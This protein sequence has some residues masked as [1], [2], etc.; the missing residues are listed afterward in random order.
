MTVIFFIAT[1]IFFLAADWVVQRF[2]ER[3][4]APAIAQPRAAEAAYPMR[5]PEGIFFA[6]SHTWLNLFPSGKVRL[7]IDDFVSGLV[8]DAKVA[9]VKSVGDQ[10]EKGEPIVILE[11]GDRRMAVRSPL[12]GTVVACNADFAASPQAMRKELFST[13]WIYTVQPAKPE[14]LRSLMLGTE[15]R[16]WMKEELGRLRDLFACPAG[17]LAPAT[18]QDGGA[19]APGVLKQLGAG[20]WKRFEETFLQ[21]Q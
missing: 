13:G 2:K 17:A 1:I 20:E 8:D 5:V 7:G 14:E 11:Q 6:R 19:P 15:S 16:S 9:L 21:V 3:R 10:V 4:E 18:L 12:A